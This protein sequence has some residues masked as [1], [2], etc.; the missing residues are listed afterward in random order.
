MTSSAHLPSVNEVHGG[1]V[2]SSAFG[3]TQPSKSDTYTYDAQRIIGHGSFGAVFL[4]KVVEIDEIVAIKKVLQDRRFKNREL[5]IMRHLVKHPHPFIMFLKHHFL[6]NGS[7]P[8]EVYLNLVLEYMP[9]TIYSVAKHHARLK[10]P[11]PIF[12]IKMY[13]YQLARALGHIHGM[14]ICHRDVKPQNLLVNPVTYTLKLCDFGSAKALIKGEPNVAY[15]CSRYYRA[16]E[17]IFGSNDYSTAI[18]VWSE[19]C[20]LA[21]LLLGSPLFPGSSGVD[22]LVEIIKVLGTPSKEE[23]K[24][25]NPNYQEFKFPTIKAH[26]LK[27]IFPSDTP[28]EAIN[29]IAMMLQYV[30]YKRVKSI[31]VNIFQINVHHM[32]LYTLFTSRP[33]Q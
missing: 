2:D 31:E 20:V 18:D 14:N 10:S 3:E 28:H 29:L 25:M 30:P 6:S 19:G 13:M 32:R 8:D 9:E 4:A 16:P 5:Q 7:K 17:L 23:L 27:T 33:F 12:A 11:I 26:P 21:E 24:S 1:N 15:I 22:Q